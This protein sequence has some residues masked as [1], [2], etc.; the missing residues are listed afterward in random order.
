MEAP[1]AVTQKGIADAIDIRVTHVPRSV[2]KLDEE[3]MIY[4]SVMHIEGMDKR[5]KA[6]FLTDKG[7]Y[8][9]KEIKRNLEERRIPLRDSKGK[10]K[11]VKINEL[12][13]ITGVKIDILDLLRLIDKGGIL[14]QKSM[15]LFAKSE[16]K[17]A[18][19]KKTG[20]FDF[21]HRITQPKKFVDRKK[22]IDTLLKWI[23]NK[24]VVLISVNG[25]TGIGKT[26]LVG[27]VLS[28]LEKDVNVFNYDFKKGEDFD[29][30]TEYLSEFLARLNRTELKSILK[31]KR[32]GQRDVLKGTINSITDTNAILVLDT[33]DQADKTSRKFISTLSQELNGLTNVKIVTIHDGKKA[34]FIEEV[35]DSA[36]FRTLELKG[37]DRKSAK[38]L[39]GI[40]KLDLEDFERIFRL[41]E[42]NPL[43]LKL[44]KSEDVSNLKKTG[45]FTSDELT[46]IKYLKSLEKL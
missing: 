6:Y 36:Q 39:L 26:S 21:P 9:A 8:H 1:Q 10:I 19:E 12:E 32:R 4:E 42:G 5:R 29:D 38:S 35:L 11:D 34:L 18:P 30:L 7:M 20:L 14:N 3:G 27:K 43:A 17:V 44:I 31:S 25:N 24:D 13:E 15:E 45:R 2:K 33:L 46:L 28:K 23:K 41:T 22:E 16:K 37:L 40:K